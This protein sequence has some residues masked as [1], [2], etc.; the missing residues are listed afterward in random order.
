[1]RP[2]ARPSAYR[3][4]LGNRP[5]VALW[6]GQAISRFGDALY[7]LA[8]LWYVLDTTGSAFAAAGIT[9]AAVGGRLV[10]SLIAGMALDRLPTRRL[11][12]AVEALRCALTAALGVCWLLGFGPSLPLHSALA[13]ALALCGALFTP[14]RMAAIPQL[15]ARETLVT[16]NALDQ[17]SASIVTTLAWGAS[18]AIVALLGPAHGLLIDAATFLASLLAVAWARWFAAPAKSDTA[19]PFAALLVGARWLCGNQLARAILAA[20]LVQAFVGGVFFPLGLHRICS[21]TSG[22]HA[23]TYGI[24]GAVYG[25]ALI[26]GSGDR[27]V[28]HA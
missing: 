9:I 16:A 2:H 15:V 12:L 1:M 25:A 18:G 7:D 19:N 4:I 14:A 6:L 13:C 23:A 10:G 21:A 5:F 11:M 22:V 3:A 26:L 17:L 28:G 20:Q 27:A 24:Q 8:L